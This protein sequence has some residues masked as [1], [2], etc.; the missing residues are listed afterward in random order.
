MG[1][2]SCPFFF[3][4][5]TILIVEDADECRKILEMT[6]SGIAD[7]MVRAVATAEEALHHAASG[8]ICALVSEEKTQASGFVF[9]LR[10]F[11]CSKASTRPCDRAACL[12]DCTVFGESIWP[13]YTRCRM[14]A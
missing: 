12:M 4:K 8:E 5:R 13:L 1:A 7:A 10:V 3:M 14:S 9:M 6:L 11:H 2:S